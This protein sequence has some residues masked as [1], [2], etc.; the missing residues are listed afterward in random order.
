[1]K[2]S[3]LQSA[4]SLLLRPSIAVQQP[5]QIRF[6]HKKASTSTQLQEIPSPTPW[7]PDVKTFLTLYGRNL[8]RYAAK[9]PTWEA[10]FTLES[11]Q[12]KELG[13]EPARD[14][15]YLIHC[16]HKYELRQFGPGGE[17]KYVQDG[18]AKLVGLVH[19][20][21]NLGVGAIG[22][23]TVLNIP[24]DQKIEDVPEEGRSLVETYRFNGQ[25]IIGPY[26][27]PIKREQ[28]A[29]VA[30]AEGMWEEKRGRKIDGG[31][32]RRAEVRFKKRLAE[33]RA[34]RESRGPGYNS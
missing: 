10:L 27:R 15:R 24:L 13:I 28:A 9:F 8:S 7:V 31:E 3:R 18:K 29:M 30:V 16:R 23:T 21:E 25:T 19:K 34:A 26:T 6:A 17:F 1:M 14:R 11:P 22:K 2:T 5:H 20:D 12:L 33:R 4:F 32:R